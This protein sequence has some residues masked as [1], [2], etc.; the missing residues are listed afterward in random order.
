MNAG[1]A[2]QQAI[3]RLEISEVESRSEIERTIAIVWL[4]EAGVSNSGFAAKREIAVW[5]STASAR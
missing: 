5:R 2:A 3:L 4:F 1:L